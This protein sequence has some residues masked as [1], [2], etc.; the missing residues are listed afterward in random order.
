VAID[1]PEVRARLRVTEGPGVQTI[2]RHGGSYIWTRKQ[3]GVRVDGLV[4]LRGRPYQVRC[5]GLVDDSAGYHARHTEWKWSA[6]VGRTTA[7]QRVAWNL[8]AGVHDDPRASERTIWLDG[9]PRE[10]GPVEFAEDLSAIRSSDGGELS[11]TAWAAR[12]DRTNALLLRS[13]YRQPFGIF[14]G[15]LPGGVRVERGYGVMESHDVWW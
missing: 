9:E 5:E 10:A 7:G 4:E 8:V 12:Q 2:S 15:E 3:G 6:G 14:E 11:F 13:S 1:A